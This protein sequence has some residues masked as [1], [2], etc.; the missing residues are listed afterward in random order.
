VGSFLNVVVWR[1]PRGETLIW[2]PSRCPRCGAHIRP[3]DNVPVFGWLKLR[4][5]CRVCRT[6]ISPRYPLVEL[7]AGVMFLALAIPELFLRGANLPFAEAPRHGR[8][9]LMIFEVRWEFVAIYIY[10][11][12]LTSVLLSWTL[13]HRDRQR[14]PAGYVAMTVWAGVVAPVVAS[15]AARLTASRTSA[16]V[17]SHVLHPVPF[18]SEAPP[19]PTHLEWFWLLAEPLAG[20]AA[21]LAC[22]LLLRSAAR[23]A[24][25]QAPT[26]AA[27]AAVGV[28]LGWQAA[29]SASL[30]AGLCLL[31][32]AALRPRLFDRWLLGTVFLAAL[33]QIFLW[34]RLE[35]ISW[36]PGSDLSFGAALVAAALIWIL[37]AA[38]GFRTDSQRPRATA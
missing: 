14:I 28:F 20:L 11:V 37:A 10:H 12:F 35:E 36:W 21:G 33:A 4:G 5:R 30:L 13:I 19:M 1:L 26:A 29:V 2:R 17:F 38:A 31:V 34:R 15:F 7:F 8:A 6:A 16:T 9:M 22:G 27:V 24:A 18:S 25:P 3:D 32:A 23:G